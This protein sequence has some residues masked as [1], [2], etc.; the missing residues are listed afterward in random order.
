MRLSKEAL[1]SLT[2]VGLTLGFI[3]SLSIGIAGGVVGNP[4]L[5]AVGVTIA[6]LITVGCLC[7]RERNIAGH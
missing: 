1:F 3:V 4:I 6:S 2:A 5:L 7:V